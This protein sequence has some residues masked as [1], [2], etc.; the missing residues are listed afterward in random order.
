MAPICRI[1]SYR[2]VESTPRPVFHLH[3]SSR[4]VR[5]MQ[6][7]EDRSS[8]HNYMCPTC[9][10]IHST[11]PEVGLNVCL[12]DSQLHNFHHPR[13]PTVTC[14]PDPFHVDWVTVSG[15][16]IP[17]LTHAFT[18][19]YKRQPRPMRVLVSAGLND[20]MRGASVTDMVAR[21][22]N[23]KEV[24]EKQNSYHSHA[25]NEMVIATII[26]PPKLVWFEGNG[27][28]PANFENKLDMLKEINSWIQFYNKDNGRTCTPSF[29]RFGVRT[30]RR[31]LGNGK[32]ANT[33]SH[34][35]SQWRQS[36]PTHD[37]VHL[38]DQW[39]V[40]MGQAVMR[41]FKGEFDRFGV[42]D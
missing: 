32:I 6:G 8:P 1:C 34:Q 19:D 35:F 23:L 3:S 17:D 5:Y 24:I 10:D 7:V 27:P 30:A 11:W 25:P 22:I 15:G 4:E 28:A 13:D 2:Q 21:F 29:H 31:K 37:M 18:V 9:M 41:W 40:R 14:P 38:S 42:L 33:Q 36:E 16:T 26:N 12:S 20:L 39:R